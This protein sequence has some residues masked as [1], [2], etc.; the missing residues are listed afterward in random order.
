MTGKLYQ[1]RYGR[2]LL[3]I[4]TLFVLAIFLKDNMEVFRLSAYLSILLMSLHL[5]FTKIFG[6]KEYSYQNR[7]ESTVLIFIITYLVIFISLPFLSSSFESLEFWFISSIV[8]LIISVIYLAVPAK[9]HAVWIPVG[10]AIVLSIY[11][12]ADNQLL[13]Q[14]FLAAILAL[15]VI[16]FSYYV[17]FLTIGGSLMTFLLSISIFGLGGI[18]WAVPILTFFILSSILSK[19]GKGIKSKF[20]DTFEKTGIRDQMQVIANGGIGGILILLNHFYP[21]DLF[22]LLFL[23]SMAVATADTWATEIGVLFNGKTRLITNFREVS[24]GVSGAISFAGTTGALLGS[25]TVVSSGVLFI[26]SEKLMLYFSLSVFGLIGSMIDSLVGATLQS[27]YHCRVC[28]KYTEKSLH[29]NER[30]KLVSGHTIISNDVVNI[31]SAFITVI[32]FY[33]FYKFIILPQIIL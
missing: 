11:L 5:I 14:S 25:L 6:E 10:T 23:A 8:S 12:T 20:E 13:L 24:P 28:G 1:G 26:S 18:K 21:S 15:I 2:I 32:L 3:F 31:T 30:T 17:K 9:Q 16:I 27:Q 19:V 22:Y 29:C 33:L 4:I 7:I